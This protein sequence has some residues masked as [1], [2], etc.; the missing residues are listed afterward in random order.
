MV[1]ADVG[2]Y[3]G[4]KGKE[5]GVGKGCAKGAW[6]VADSFVAPVA[7]RSSAKGA[8]LAPWKKACPVGR[9][10]Y[11]PYPP[12]STNRLVRGRTCQANPK[13]GPMV[14]WPSPLVAEVLLARST[15]AGGTPGKLEPTM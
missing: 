1:V 14:F 8:A 2:E 9:E 12:R 15:P 11:I 3:A 13:R 4:N 10:K 6:N 5:A 7:I